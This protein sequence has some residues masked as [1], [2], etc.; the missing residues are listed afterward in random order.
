[1]GSSRSIA[2]IAVILSFSLFAEAQSK[3][4]AARRAPVSRNN[5][6]WTIG[7]FTAGEKTGLKRLSDDTDF[8]LS[9]S[10]MVLNIGR[11]WSWSVGRK[12][13]LMDIQGLYGSG[14]TQSRNEQLV[15]FSNADSFYGLSAAFGGHY[16]YSTKSMWL[17]SLLDI[18][19]RQYQR[20]APP[21]FSFQGYEQRFLAYLKFELTFPISNGTQVVQYFGIPLNE[22][23]LYWGVGL[24]F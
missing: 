15:Y 14:A 2:L 18:Q 8:E 22:R 1:M 23:D 11:I 3:S 20:K 5:Q 24:R 19:W 9:S 7:V 17:A 10:Q 6:Q 16:N 13:Y 4:T 12:G 21:G